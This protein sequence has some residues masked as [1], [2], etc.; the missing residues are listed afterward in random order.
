MNPEGESL[1][2]EDSHMCR[3]RAVKASSPNVRDWGGGGS[4][5][6]LRDG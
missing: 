5:L 4:Q 3:S 6:D 2:A 1:K